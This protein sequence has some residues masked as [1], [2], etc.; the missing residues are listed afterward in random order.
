MVSDLIDSFSNSWRVDLIMD[1]FKRDDVLL[2]LSIPLSQSGLCDRLV[3]HHNTNEVYL[4][5]SGYGLAMKL[6]EDGA[7][8]RKGRGAPSEI[9]KHNQVKDRANEDEIYQDFAFG[10]WRLWKNR[11]EVVFNGIHR[12]PLKVL[13]AWRKCT[14]E[15]R[16]SLSQDP[17]DDSPKTPKTTKGAGRLSVQWQKPRYAIIKINTYAAWC[18]STIRVGVGW[19]GRD[20]AGLLQATGGSGTGYCHSAAAAEAYVIC[21]A[22]GACID[23]GFDDVIIESDA[24][25]IILM[26]RKEVALDFSIEC[27][28]GDIEVLAQRL[29]SVTFAFVPREC[30]RAGHSVAKYVFNE[31]RAFNWDCIGPAFLF[32]FLAHDVNISIC[33]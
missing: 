16:V 4:V 14:T 32:N 5:K 18:K 26:L 28:L 20:F 22:L 23:H 27:I 29:K 33:I 9:N 25:T 13:K 21:A 6:M 12:Q 19:L 8:G 2:I 11:N 3:W 17:V 15:Y 7:L 30:N 1:G 24:K 31:G 10:L